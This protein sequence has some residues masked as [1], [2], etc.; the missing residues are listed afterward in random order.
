MLEHRFALPDRMW[1]GRG[2]AAK[3]G[4]RIQ[5]NRFTRVFVVIDPVVEST[6]FG[7]NVL[8]SLE[9]PH[10]KFIW[11]KIETNNPRKHVEDASLI[12][13]DFNAELVVVIGGGSAIDL[14]KSA[15]VLAV[16]G[17]RLEDYWSNKP[18]APLPPIYAIPTTCGTGSE[19][20]PYAVILDPL[21]H[22]KRGIESDYLIPKEAFLDPASLD[23][24]S[25][26]LIGATGLDAFCHGL[27]AYVSAKSTSLT[28][29]ATLGTLIKIKNNILPAALEHDPN[30]L[31]ILL[32][33]A[34]TSRLLYPRTGLTIAHAM[35]HPLGAYFNLHHGDA[36]ARVI[37]PSI[38]FNAETEL[39][40]YAELARIL[41]IT[42]N[43]R[44][45]VAVEQLIEWLE[46]LLVNLN[47][48]QEKLPVSGD[49]EDTISKMAEATMT[50]SNIP[51]NP[52]L[53]KKSD[54]ENLFSS[55][56]VP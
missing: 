19:V 23:S 6:N 33:C 38:R 24:L 26:L 36:V 27:E 48:A 37:V 39:P 20:S 32:V 25:S 30:S 12:L 41:S 46:A 31:E 11:D 29:V 14:A 2:C 56:L 35:S 49:I 22:R 54:V 44:D 8:E 42:D 50:S 53:V 43:R 21:T 52:R 3:V 1:F 45:A 18:I 5:E 16:C 10:K 17:G 13:R 28:Q 55:L 9:F 47:L 4:S 7:K 51:S 15:L 34:A 40:R